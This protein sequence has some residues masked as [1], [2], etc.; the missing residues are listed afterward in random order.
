MVRKEKILAV[1]KKAKQASLKL[2]TDIVV[3]QKN[4]LV[5]YTPA[6]VFFDAKTQLEKMIVYIAHNEDR[7]TIQVCGGRHGYSNFK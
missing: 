3:F 5:I 7:S 1:L 2:K 6:S 4:D